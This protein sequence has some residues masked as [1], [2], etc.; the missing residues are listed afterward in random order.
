[1]EKQTPHVALRKIR[2]LVSSGHVEATWS[3]LK[4]A[5]ALGLGFD[6]ML[7]T[8]E[9]LEPKDFHKSMTAHSD[10]RAWQDVYRPDSPIGGLYVK[11]MVPNELLIVSFKER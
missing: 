8:L 2:E 3:A 10:H 7:E 5:A 4:G 1:L 6:D 9:R 11:L